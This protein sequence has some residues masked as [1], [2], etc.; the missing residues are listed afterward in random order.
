LKELV[1]LPKQASIKL[2][3]A[4]DSLANHPRPIR[5]KKLKGEK[6]YLWRIRVGDYRVIY[7]IEDVVK[8]VE[9]RK[10]GNRKDIY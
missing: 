4:I 9:I 6:E 10:I 3:Q 1:E 8:I 5:C 7:Q 2:T